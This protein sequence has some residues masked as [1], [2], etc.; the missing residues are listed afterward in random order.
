M[1]QRKLREALAFSTEFSA[2]E[3][4]YIVR[5]ID[6]DDSAIGELRERRKANGNDA[7]KIGFDY[8][9]ID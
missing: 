2:D 6:G 9:D 3:L 7:R 1:R 8:G 4:D 5:F